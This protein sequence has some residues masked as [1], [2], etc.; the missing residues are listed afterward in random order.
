M[1]SIT[2]DEM[3]ML[4][5]QKEVAIAILQRQLREA[6]EKLAALEAPK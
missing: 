2:F 4:I 6:Q 5:G 3:V 1:G